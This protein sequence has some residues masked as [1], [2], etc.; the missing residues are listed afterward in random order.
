MTR[1]VRLRVILLVR[2]TKDCQKS[3]VNCRPRSV[4][5]TSGLPKRVIQPLS[6]RR[7]IIRPLCQSLGLLLAN[8][9]NDPP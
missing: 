5:I 4:V 8:G 1:R 3:E 2:R 7:R 9:S 6:L